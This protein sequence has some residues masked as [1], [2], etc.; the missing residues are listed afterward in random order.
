MWSSVVQSDLLW[1]EAFRN[2]LDTK[3]FNGQKRA[4]QS[5]KNLTRSPGGT[6][7]NQSFET[8][9]KV[10]LELGPHGQQVHGDEVLDDGGEVDEPGGDAQGVG[11]LQ[12]GEAPAR[13]QC[14]LGQGKPTLPTPPQ[15]NRTE[16]RHCIKKLKV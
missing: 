3:R 15:N 10:P 16:A 11:R 2:V 9:G 7:G 1:L 5:K 8:W 12:V 13:P 6:A 4:V 14:G